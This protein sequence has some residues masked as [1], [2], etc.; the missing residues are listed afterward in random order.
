MKMASLSNRIKW[1]L[2]DHSEISLII[3]REQPRPLTILYERKDSKLSL[4]Q[5]LISP[6]LQTSGRYMINIWKSTKSFKRKSSKRKERD[7]KVQA[8]K[9]NRRRKKHSLKKTPYFPIQW[10]ALLGLCK[11][12]SFKTQKKLSSTTI[13]TS[14]K[15]LTKAMLLKL[16]QYYRC[17]DSLLKNLGRKM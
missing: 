5:P 4:P 7:R 1:S 15:L 6:A 14:K 8:E 16:A 17:G 9:I 11:E 12:W 13:A 10:N 3:Q 2:S